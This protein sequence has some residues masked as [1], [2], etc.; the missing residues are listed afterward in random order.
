[1]ALDNKYGPIDLSDLNI[2][3]DEPVFILRG[4]DATAV[5]CLVRYANL[6]RDVGRDEFHDSVV[7]VITQFETWQAANPDKV[8]I[9]D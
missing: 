6:H 2:P 3:E 5:A 9:P 4:Q 7:G 8:K 1:M